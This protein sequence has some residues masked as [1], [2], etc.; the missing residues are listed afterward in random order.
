MLM[1]LPGQRDSIITL[2]I[3]GVLVF[4][5]I[6]IVLPVIG[7]RIEQQRRLT[8]DLE[9]QYRRVDE[10]LAEGSSHR[11]P[12]LS[13]LSDEQLG[14]TPTRYS[15]NKSAPYI[16][17]TLDDEQI[18]DALRASDQPPYPFV[19]VWGATKAGKSRTLV[20]ALRAS[21]PPDTEVL[22]PIDGRALAELVQIGL[23]FS[24]E[25]PGLVFLDDLTAVDLEAL[26]SAVLSG[27]RGRAV[28][29]GTMTA[30]RRSQV[31]A[32]DGEVTRIARIALES[33]H[34]HELLFRPPN[35]TEY[36]EAIRLYP[37]ESFRGSIAETL[38][39]GPELLAKYRAGQDTNPAG[40]ALVQ[41]AVDWRRAG[42]HRPI[43]DSE[44]RQLFALYLPLIRAGMPATT[45]AYRSGLHKWAAVPIASQVALLSRAT[46][47]NT[48]SSVRNAGW[49]ALDYV[50]AADEG[51]MP[52]HA[53]RPI[54]NELWPELLELITPSEALAVSIAAHTRD[55]LDLA[56]TAARIAARA[57]DSDQAAAAAF[58]LAFT[59]FK[60]RD[61]QEAEAAFETLVASQHPEYFAG[62]AF[63]LGSLLFRRGDIERAK[64]LYR[65][66]IHAH[67]PEYTPAAAYFLGELLRQQGDT[68]AASVA[69]REA[70]KSN[71]GVHAPGALVGL[72]KILNEEGDV[73]GAKA[74]YL[75]AIEL[76]H[77]E[78][79]LSARFSLGKLM[80]DQGDVRGAKSA[81]QHLV[82]SGHTEYAAI[83]AVNLGYL[84]HEQGEVTAS[85]AA[86]QKAI[87][88]DHPEYAYAAMYNLANMLNGEGDVEGAEA[89]YKRLMSSGHAE[90][91]P[92]AAVNLGSLFREQGKLGEA[93]AAFQEAIESGHAEYSSAALVNLGAMLIEQG[94]ASEA[95]TSLRRV[96][97]SGHDESRPAA[98]LNLGN[99]LQDRGD[100]ENAK[101][102][103]RAAADGH[104][105][106]RAAALISL[107]NVLRKEGEFG[108]AIKIW[109]EVIDYGGDMAIAAL[110]NMGNM[111]R[112]EGSMAE[113]I[114]AYRRVIDSGAVD[115]SAMAMINLGNLLSELGDIDGA[116][117]AYQQAINSGHSD[118]GMRASQA[119]QKL[120]G[121]TS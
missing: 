58:I 43:S 89:A 51:S 3:L 105:A 29:V 6:S 93:K 106:T 98:L 85:K 39:G 100:T 27:V 21:L 18:R 54:P 2:S 108:E 34:N 35:E 110:F 117:L 65:E 55:Q 8:E 14:A 79:E 83:A 88:S 77:A 78:H 66:V 13:E 10:L 118:A 33:A 113:A 104:T 12:R 44:L 31:M 71:H 73:E 30:S 111:L 63:A 20:E 80:K 40:Y 32:S 119:L 95:E 97:E 22:V 94:D 87:A 101:A 96:I 82:D 64:A 25:T 92:K 70:I 48:D 116:K 67:H 23:P 81:Y 36:Q 59:L 53:A 99:L 60:K 4:L 69:F 103:Y 49:V 91:A 102:A 46:F 28:L 24:S 5:A 114:E 38:V 115:Y 61:L 112:D 121:S 41:A 62:A 37:K 1:Q 45:A 90:Y 72:G 42:L 16:A 26:P 15:R 11:L 86:Y 75:Q 84:L 107:G 7:Y 76:G 109:Q 74:A 56:A 47:A 19:V 17:R 9:K 120:F 50:V 57:A 68:A 52:D